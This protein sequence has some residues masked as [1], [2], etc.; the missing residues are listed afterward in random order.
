M[1]KV[2][3]EKVTLRDLGIALNSVLEG[4]DRVELDGGINLRAINVG[5]AKALAKT[6]KTL[7]G[8]LHYPATSLAMATDVVNFITEA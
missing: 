1:P 3:K 6:S 8:N 2:E 7:P 5:I 4:E